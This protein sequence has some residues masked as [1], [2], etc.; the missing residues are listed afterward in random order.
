MFRPCIFALLNC[1]AAGKVD[2]RRKYLCGYLIEDWRE[3]AEE[4]KSAPYE[5]LWTELPNLFRDFREMREEGVRFL[6]GTDAG[7]AFMYTGFSLHDELQQLVEHVGFS[8]M[9]A[10]RIGTGGVAGFYGEQST[11]GALEVNQLAE[12]VLLDADPLADIRNTKRVE[13][14]LTQGRWLSRKDL[15]GILLRVER[16]ART[17]CEGSGLAQPHYS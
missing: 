7:V 8:P 14:V 5:P 15:D 16:S 11:F 17:G 3:Q 13:G 2:A 6:A 1:V 12:S 4:G 10:L 9:D